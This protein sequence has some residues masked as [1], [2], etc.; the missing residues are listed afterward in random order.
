MAKA[1]LVGLSGGVDSAVAALLLKDAGVNITGVT[2]RMM[3]DGNE[4]SLTD[5]RRVA[6]AI[7]IPH[8]V[9]D[10][11]ARFRT[12]VLDPFAASYRAGRTPNPCVRCNRMVKWAGLLDAADACGADGIATGHYARILRD[13]DTGRLTI[14]ES[15]GGKDQSYALCG[16]TQAQLARTH[17]PLGAMTKEA[18]R[19][20]AA[21]RGIPVADKP[22]S[23]EICFVPD[24]DHAGF[25]ARHTGEPD[26]P[27]D[28]V[29]TDGRVIG[30]H[31]GLAHYTIGQRK[32]LGAFG[33]RVFVTS[34]VPGANA[35]VLGAPE[36]LL[37]TRLTADALNF[38]ALAPEDG[39]LASESGIRAMGKIRYNQHP[40]P[41]TLWL[42]ESTIAC[43]FDTP[44]RAVT[45]GQAAVFYCGGLL[46]CAGTIQ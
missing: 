10:M 18:V 21:A 33:R 7:G 19:A 24:D 14:A 22:D 34:I 15:P 3:E 37:R 38:M 6:A 16:L 23:Q 29:D 30:R 20:I 5:A 46:L 27:G 25:I 8:E 41:C 28:F 2:L 4:A 44:Q 9:L 45:P 31:R 12:E 26:A 11:S 36:D 17:M 43:E 32:G 1:L 13:E 40:A 39:A 35:V 42:R